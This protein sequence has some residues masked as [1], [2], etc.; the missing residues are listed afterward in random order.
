[1]NLIQPYPKQQI[2]KIFPDI[3]FDNFNYNTDT[4]IMIDDSIINDNL[5]PFDKF[6]NGK[7][8]RNSSYDENDYPKI[9]PFKSNLNTPNSAIK[10]TFGKKDIKNLNG[11]NNNIIFDGNNNISNNINFNAFNNILENINNKNEDNKKDKSKKKIIFNSF[12]PNTFKEIQNQKQTQKIKNKLSARKSRLKKKLYVEQLEKQ[13]ILVK[14]ELDDIKQNM[15]LNK[16]INNN[17]IIP[18]NENEHFI[19][20]NNLCQNC[21][22]ID[23][24]KAEEKIIVSEKSEKKNINIIN[25]FT[26]KQR[27]ILEQL[28]VK[29]IQVMMPIKIKMFQNKYLKLSTFDKDDNINVIKNKIEENLQAIKE[30]YDVESFKDEDNGGVQIKKYQYDGTKSKSMAYQIYNFYNNLKNYVN[31]FEKIYFSLI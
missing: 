24:L 28:L 6:F 30:L 31:E 18:L 21:I 15:N 5:E 17:K 29:Q 16:K 20:N 7:R 23:G 14:K 9:F 8:S 4:N 10:F 12:Q 13:Y 26:A 22:N 27:I 25:S 19:S 11:N 2:N 3:S 1:M